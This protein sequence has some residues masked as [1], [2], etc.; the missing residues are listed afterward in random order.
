[1]LVLVI[2]SCQKIETFV[3]CTF[4]QSPDGRVVIRCYTS[5]M[6]RFSWG[7]LM[8]TC[9]ALSACSG[10]QD[11]NSPIDPPAPEVAPLD[12]VNNSFDT[13]MAVALDDE[14]AGLDTMRSKEDVSYF[15]FEGNAGQ[16][17]EL[18]TSSSPYS[19][20]TAIT[21][22]DP[23]RNPIADNDDGAAFSTDPVDARIVTRLERDGTYYVSVED[24]VSSP[25][26]FERESHPYYRLQI[27]DLAKRGS[28]TYDATGGA[29][30]V[31]FEEFEVGGK[32]FL[33]T[34]ILGAHDTSEPDTY[35]FD[36]DELPALI[37]EQHASGTFGNGSSASAATI[38]VAEIEQV[39]D[40]ARIDPSHGVM[41]M[42]PSLPV[43]RYELTVHRNDPE[44]NQAGFYAVDVLLILDNPEELEET[45]NDTPEGAEALPFTETRGFILS[46]L[47]EGDVDHFKFDA[48]AGQDVSVVCSS[49]SQG[50]GLVDLVAAVTDPEGTVI[51][52]GDEPPGASLFLENVP[53]SVDGPHYLRLSSSDRLPD[54]MGDWVRCA[55]QVSE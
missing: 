26:F 45:S 40:Y 54:V 37:A 9:C 7:I 23:E 39:D 28:V 29:A 31:R 8:T 36:V 20:N 15:R 43:G 18:T 11:Q 33:R 51:A 48:L 55:V 17:V 41:E 4:M 44:P 27:Y 47:G 5:T 21:L 10:S 32:M 30:E 24:R 2:G 6:R 50:S 38:S 1:M 52:S 14:L 16:W 3:D 19:P 34:L 46:R 49:R 22:Y 35:R 42:R 12:I 53:V 13:A 25:R